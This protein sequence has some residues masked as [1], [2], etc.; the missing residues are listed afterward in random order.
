[1]KRVPPQAFYAFTTLIQPFDFSTERA[2]HIKEIGNW[3]LK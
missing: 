1:M 2:Q 3:N